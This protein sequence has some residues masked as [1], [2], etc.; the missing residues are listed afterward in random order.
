MDIEHPEIERELEMTDVERRLAAWRPA[1]S[2]L[3]R[4][5]ML[6]D[7][8]RAAARADG[9]SGSWRLATA[10]VALV[11]AL[12]GG[13]LA[14]ERSHSLTLAASLASASGTKPQ[15]RTGEIEL[16]ATGKTRPIEPFAPAATLPS[17]RGSH[18]AIRP[19]HRP[20]WNSSVSIIG[21]RAV[22]SS[23][24]RKSDRCNPG[25]KTA[26]SISDPS[27][28][29]S[30]SRLRRCSSS[31]CGRPSFVFYLSNPIV[32]RRNS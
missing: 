3:D 28:P 18:E 16:P 25:I 14:N 17:R 26:S 5:R 19:R 27:A 11:A 4:D 22:N 10:A 21:Q 12:L 23:C 29:F 2:S 9:L 24:S 31:A 7:A 8:G 15:P 6:Y 13:L 30:D 20:T 1:T 32:F